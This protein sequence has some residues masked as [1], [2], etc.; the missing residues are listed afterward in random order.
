MKKYIYKYVASAALVLTTTALSSCN[1]MFRDAP[2]NQI[3][4]TKVWESPQ[5]LDEY[6]NAWY[7]NMSDGFDIY[8]PSIALVKSASR[9]YMPWFAD[10]VV[11]SK[12]D[13][14]NA[15]YGDLLKGNEQEIT[16]WA[17]MTWINYYTQIQSI[18][19]LLEN[20]G[21][22]ANG[23]QKDRLLGEAHFFRAYYYYMAWRK[24]GGPLL[25]DHT[26]DPLHSQ[27]KFP[28]ASYKQTV[29]FIIA[30]AKQAADMLPTTYNASDKGRATKGAALMLQA[31]T[32]FWASSSI[33]QNKEKD[34]LGFTDD[35][36]AA[37]LQKAKEAYDSLFATNVYDLVPITSTTQDGIKNEY[38][39]I[40]LTKN[41][42][43]SIFEVQHSDDGDYANKFGHKL[44][45]N[46]ASPFFTGTTAGYTPT[47]N[48]VDE[49]G[50]QEGKT[51]DARHP[52]EGR[53]YR[54]YANILYD[55]SIFKGHKM[56]IHYT[57]GTAG[58]DLKAYGTSTSAAVTRTGYYMGKFVDEA[59]A[60]DD[61]ET[62]ASKQNYIIWR[63]A[64]ALLDYAEIMFRLGDTDEALAM[65][66]KIR[67]RVHM[68][69]LQSITWQQIVNE[70]R[71]EMAFEETTYWDMFRWGEA[72]EKMN[73][74]Q[75]PLKMM[76]IDING[77]DTTYR[78]CNLN[79]FPGRIRV[80][81]EMQYYLPIPWSEVQYQGIEQNPSWTEM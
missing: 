34:Y 5:L 24:F 18:N 65:V 17:R 68:P 63:Y 49:Y 28:R 20:S 2:I 59:Q 1:D 31:K 47:Q 58:V 50:M 3:S 75:N 29:D 76:R 11:P 39:N 22:I 54:F 41:S 21:K 43:E 36:S 46:A 12:N 13:W 33:F 32:Y 35:Q 40:F 19:T 69:L 52:Y 61:N 30:E 14:Y 72:V 73:G 45:R 56:D 8:V 16:N 37:M 60:I 27:E 15:G 74:L 51:Y 71:V 53:D 23:E 48:H 64:E 38:R 57:N 77:N 10:Q 66:N 9:Y 70:R 67:D 62:Y 6:V 26:Y 55:G 79:R 44:D 80:F 78:V 25:I 81:K 7:R 4:E 42:Q